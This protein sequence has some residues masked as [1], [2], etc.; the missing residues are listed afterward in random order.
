[1]IIKQSNLYNL[2]PFS[3]FLILLFHINISNVIF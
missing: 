3:S 1:M 2:K